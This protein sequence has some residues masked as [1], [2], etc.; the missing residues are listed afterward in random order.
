MNSN[1]EELLEFVTQ[2]LEYIERYITLIKNGEVTPELVNHAI[3]TYTGVNTFLISQHLLMSNDYDELLAEYQMIWDS[4]YLTARD[5]INAGRV[6]SK[7]AANPEI[8]AEA[9][10]AHAEEYQEWQKKLRLLNKKVSFYSS[11]V[12]AWEGQGRKIETLGY[13]LRAELKALPVE[14]GILKKPVRTVK[15]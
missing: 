1:Q 14:N 6:A 8:E 15:H 9:R 10:Q 2:K 3:A 4:W 5:K 13:N 7:L 12:K 11:L